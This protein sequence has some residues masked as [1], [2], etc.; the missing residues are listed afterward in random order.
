MPF[1]RLFVLLGPSVD[2]MMPAH[3][4]ED[5]SSLLSLLIQ[6]LI[7]SGN[8]VTDLPRNNVLPGIW[9]SFNPVMLTHKIKFTDSF[10][11]CVKSDKSDEILCVISEFGSDNH[12]VSSNCIF[13]LSMSQFFG[14]SCY[15]RAIDTKVNVL[16]FV[17]STSFLLQSL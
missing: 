6:M 14:E 5:R 8:N 12:F 2:W 13:P 15:F 7:S 16:C 17:I 10:L 4:D 3:Y 9:A 11:E 1:L